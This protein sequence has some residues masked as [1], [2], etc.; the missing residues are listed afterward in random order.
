MKVRQLISILRNLD[1]DL[2][3]LISSDA[4]GNNIKTLS[5]WDSGEWNEDIKEYDSYSQNVNSICFWPD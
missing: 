5:E 3:V 2:D 4:E 1:P